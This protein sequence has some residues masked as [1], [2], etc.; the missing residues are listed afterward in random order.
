MGGRSAARWL[1]LYG[2]SLF[3]AVCRATAEEE[4][5]G[6]FSAWLL[7]QGA[8]Y[9]AKFSVGVDEK[10]GLR[11][12]VTKEPVAKGTAL[13]TIPAS[14][15]LTVDKV[16]EEGTF[17]Q[18]CGRDGTDGPEVMSPVHTSFALFLLEQRAGKS[19]WQPWVD[20]LPEEVSGLPLFYSADD[21]AGLQASPLRR[22]I[23]L[24]Q[25]SVAQ[26]HATLASSGLEITLEDYKWARAVV[27]SRVFDLSK[28]PI[29]NFDKQVIAM[30][31]LAD[32]INHP[33]DG[34]EDNVQPSYDVSSGTFRFSA[35]RDISVGEG[36]YWDYGFRSNRGSLDHYG[37]V[38][39]GKIFATDMPLFFKLT[40]FPVSSGRDWKQERISKAVLDGLLTVDPDGSV[41]HDFSLTL[42]GRHAERL[43][44]HM[45]FMVWRPRT[46][47]L[48]AEYCPSTYCS[49]VSLAN[50]RQALKHLA[51]LLEKLQAAYSTSVEEDKELQTSLS[52]S[53]G[54]SWQTLIVRYG[55]KMIIR[56]FLRMLSAVDQLFDL[57]PSALA[58]EVTEKWNGK[59]DIHAY[60]RE[61]LTSLL[62]GEHRKRAK[63]KILEDRAAAG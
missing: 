24:E 56:G 26:D 4:V 46:A 61:N 5:F 59:S 31:P 3:G 23:E 21:L 18:Q 20:T 19:L 54:S 9:D 50:E 52:P 57:S 32:F 17:W 48:L 40:D 1:L 7:E 41:L 60:V 39:Q 6:A 13:F 8:K 25:D 12:L 14:L 30:V 2:G 63:R 28:L 55:E 49:P 44:G 11:G 22:V 27:R 62:E 51:S 16:R 53:S 36:L 33:P 15:I 34:V 45:R 58:A 29:G 47:D 42:R 35:V 38:A 10:T 43:L 37:F